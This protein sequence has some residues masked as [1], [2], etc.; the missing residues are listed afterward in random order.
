MNV[1]VEIEVPATESF[2]EARHHI[3]L[4][5]KSFAYGDGTITGEEY[6]RW[7]EFFEASKKEWLAKDFTKPCNVIFLAIIAKH[8]MG[9]A[10]KIKFTRSCK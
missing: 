3:R 5:H 6:D 9:I 4:L 8:N 7:L 10:R 2:N 1:S